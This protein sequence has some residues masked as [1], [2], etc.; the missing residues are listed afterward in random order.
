MQ[1]PTL[2]RHSQAPWTLPSLDAPL[3]HACVCP[4]STCL[5]LWHPECRHHTCRAPSWSRRCWGCMARPGWAGL[6][7]GGGGLPALPTAAGSAEN[8][9]GLPAKALPGQDRKCWGLGWVGALTTPWSALK[10]PA[11][12]APPRAALRVGGRACPAQLPHS[13]LG[14]QRLVSGPS[15]PEVRAAWPARRSPGNPGEPLW[16]CFQLTGRWGQLCAPSPSSSA[17]GEGTACGSGCCVGS[18]QG[19]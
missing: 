16:S 2:D 19:D 18:Q 11:P 1:R 4:S 13:R 15:R 9:C 3:A 10:A 6:G 14:P 5:S 17:P 8:N 12:G 7:W